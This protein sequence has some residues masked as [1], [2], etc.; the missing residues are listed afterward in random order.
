M[1]LLG[2]FSAFRNMLLNRFGYYLHSA[3]TM[4]VGTDYATDLIQKI[5]LKP[6]VIFD[7]GAN[8]GQTAEFYREIFPNAEIYSFEPIPATFNELTKRC[9]DMFGVKLFNLAFGE[10][11]ESRKIK[12]VKDKASVINSINDD[13]QHDLEKSENGYDEV[14]ISIETLDNFLELNAIKS[15][16]LLKIDTEGFEIPVLKGAQ[17]LLESGKVAAIIC[18]AGFM[19]TNTRNTYIGDINDVLESHGYALFGVYE[20]GHLGFKKGIHYGNLLYI[21]KE[22]RENEYENWQYGY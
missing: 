13:F 6:K 9:G 12:I 2:I 15:I 17:K 7:I 19:R 11:T 4:P 1:R 8:I 5:N 21:S 10:S 22:F 20:M 18:E 14:E 3:K 16:D